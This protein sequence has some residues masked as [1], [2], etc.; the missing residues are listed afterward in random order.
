MYKYGMYK[1]NFLTLTNE[2]QLSWFHTQLLD[3]DLSQHQVTRFL[4]TAT[5]KEMENNSFTCL[6]VQILAIASVST[7]WWWEYID[8]YSGNTCDF[9]AQHKYGLFELS[10]ICG[11]SKPLDCF[12]PDNSYRPSCLVVLE[13]DH[14]ICLSFLPIHL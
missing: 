1:Y 3:T 5:G 6:F 10:E 11:T 8:K 4:E 2:S 7:I 9:S 14:C 13:L 12:F